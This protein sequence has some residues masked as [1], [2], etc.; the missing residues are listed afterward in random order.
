[1]SEP[2]PS[3]RGM[4]AMVGAFT[5]LTISTIGLVM[6]LYWHHVTQDWLDPHVVFWMPI[7]W[8]S[9]ISIFIFTRIVCP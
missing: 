7:G 3:I 1:M 5:C 2:K 6:I 4:I 9:A 8:V